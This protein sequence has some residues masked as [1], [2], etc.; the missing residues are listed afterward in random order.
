V[1][2]EPEAAIVRDIF[3]LYLR[4]PTV[5]DLCG[6]AAARGWRNKHWVNRLGK[7]AGGAVFDKARLR[8]LLANPLCA[9]LIRC[10]DGLRDAQHAAI[11]DR[12]TWDAAQAKLAAKGPRVRRRRQAWSSLLGGLLFCGCG[13]AMV[14]HFTSRHGRQYHFYVCGTH[15]RK[16]AAACPGSRVRMDELDTFV[17]DRLRAMGRDRALV[18]A[19]VEATRQREPSLDEAELRLVLAELTP[20]WDAMHLRER[21]RVMNLVLARVSYTALTHDIQFTL[22]DSGVRTLA[23]ELSKEAA[24]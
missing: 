6:E 14:H 1:V 22:R 9:G 24:L 7:P 13:A 10:G 19:T 23:R 12:A 8:S 15:I 11:I 3:A 20:L 2:N 5:A 18:A 4:L 21:Q 17:V 16:R